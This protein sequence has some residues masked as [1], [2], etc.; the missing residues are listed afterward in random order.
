[1][2]CHCAIKQQ[3]KK[4]V[5]VPAM[6]RS[7]TP[8]S[9]L[10]V[11]EGIFAVDKPPSTSSAQVIRNL[12]EKFD[13]SRLFQPWLRQEKARLEVARAGQRKRRHRPLHVKMGHGGTL[14]PEATG[15]LILG[16]GSGTKLLGSFLNCTKSYETVVLFGAA[17]DT[18]DCWGRIVGQKQYEQITR[19][20]VEDALKQYRGKIMQKPP[21]YSALHV[22][23]K[24]LYEYARE[25][26]KV[27]IEIQPRPVEVHELEIV[28]WYEGGSHAWRWPA[29]REED[30]E[31][32]A[33][34]KRRRLSSSVE[35]NQDKATGS[36]ETGELET[37]Q[38]EG[39][40][41]K[42]PSITPCPAPAVRL[43]MTVSSGFYV[44]S[45]CHDLGQAVDSLACMVSLVRTRQGDFQLGRNVLSYDDLCQDEDIWGK[46]VEG[47]LRA[48]NEKQQ[49]KA[50]S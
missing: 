50:C 31:E 29:E 45:L 40:L 16:V 41:P 12:Q 6:K 23:G 1:M 32:S 20:R 10:A 35:P 43:R 44:R 49:G 15:V 17:T 48:W 9:N 13:P 30:A 36:A 47:M 46:Q 18:Y 34:K 2:N 22:R 14:D 37:V 38:S 24:R 8:V 3:L 19:D 26:L 21:I 28:D 4:V 25:G 7:P 39:N 42:A 5:R 27:P 11:V 33:E